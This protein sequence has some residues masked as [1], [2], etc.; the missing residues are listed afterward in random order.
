MPLISVHYVVMAGIQ[1]FTSIADRNR[2]GIGEPAPEATRPVWLTHKL[3]M[4]DGWSDP[5]SK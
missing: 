5:C 3:G 1:R 4:R 2:E